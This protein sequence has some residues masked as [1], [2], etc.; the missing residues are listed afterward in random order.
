M[1]NPCVDT[2][3]NW[4]VIPEQVMEE[5]SYEI[6]SDPMKI[7]GVPALFSVSNPLCGELTLTMSVDLTSKPIRY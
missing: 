7:T 5:V 3:E 1:K 2:A 4:I 6:N